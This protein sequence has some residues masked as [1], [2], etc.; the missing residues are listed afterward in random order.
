LFPEFSVNALTVTDLNIDGLKD[1]IVSNWIS[2]EL[3]VF[4]SFGILKYGEP[5]SLRIEEGVRSVAAGFIDADANPDL[6]ILTA[7]G[8]SCL[9]Y[10]GDSFGDFTRSQTIMLD[11]PVSSLVLAD[12]NNDRTTDM[13][14]LDA[15]GG[16][17]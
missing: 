4:T 10:A 12:V 9:I 2:N 8:T 5:L 17:I 7:R 1:F 6:A 13:F 16:G 3:L 15:P 11:E 14:F